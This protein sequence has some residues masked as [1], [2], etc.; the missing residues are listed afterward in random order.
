MEREEARVWARM[1]GLVRQL[2]EAVK[3][4]GDVCALFPVLTSCCIDH[5][6]SQAEVLDAG[7]LPLACDELL[8]AR[9]VRHQVVA[10]QLLETCAAHERVR[11]ELAARAGL[12]EYLA[13]LLARLAG[14]PPPAKGAAEAAG[15]RALLQHG[16]G[17]LRG[18]LLHSGAREALL[19]TGTVAATVAA[20]L[21]P[22]HSAPVRESAA[23]AATL[24]SADRRLP[25][26]ALGLLLEAAAGA[27]KEA[28][29]PALVREGALAVLLNASAGPEGRPAVQAA[30]PWP[31]LV[32]LL[33]DS[34]LRAAA[35]NLLSRFAASAPE[36]A[37]ALRAPGVPERVLALVG[38]DP[39]SEAAA[40]RLAAALAKT[41][42]E[43]VAAL[44]GAGL[45][46]AL[47][48]ALGSGSAQTLGNACLC[49]AD[50][51]AADGSLVRRVREAGLA[52]RLVLVMQQQKDAV[53]RNAAIA[54]ARLSK[55]GGGEGARVLELLRERRAIEL[56]A[57]CV[58][59]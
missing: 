40:V 12:A 32:A 38:G 28:K 55:A 53:Q 43:G 56:M 57:T 59:P 24:L 7:V 33:Q 46:G 9:D 54:L 18:L 5:G 39:S 37:A 3:G 31:A 42:P 22:P 16:A 41:G 11:G 44:A 2:C 27:L 34:A 23:A 29:A 51:V 17:L 4:G 50:A 21:R 8:A 49:L 15:P 52:E 45:V 48:G 6:P 19:R 30:A 13:A 36:A 25:G 1:G 10:L 47:A 20:L 26:A 58:K 35:A 14:A